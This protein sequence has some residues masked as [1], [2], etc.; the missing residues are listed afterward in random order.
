MEVNLIR[1]TF[2][3]II[4]F[5]MAIFGGHWFTRWVLS[6]FKLCSK[7]Q[8]LKNAGEWVG[9]LER[10]LVYVLIILDLSNVLGFVVAAK[11]IARFEELK[12]RKFSEYFLVGTLASI[13]WA[14]AIAGLIRYLI[15]FDP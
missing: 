9:Y 8:G 13:T 14:I 10:A 11:S 6:R 2:I 3:V 12:D 5:F 1:L 15:T 7:S 4:G